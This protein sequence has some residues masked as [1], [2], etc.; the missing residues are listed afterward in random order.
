MINALTRT[1]EHVFGI[2][3]P[4]AEANGYQVFTGLAVDHPSNAV[5]LQA[6]GETV[7]FY[8]T[9]PQPSHHQSEILIR[10]CSD[11]RSIMELEEISNEI[12]AAL[13]GTA[14]VSDRGRVS[15]CI[16]VGQSY[17]PEQRNSGQLQVLLNRYELV[18]AEASDS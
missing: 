5:I 1:I 18:L 10:I 12:D 11:S 4:I 13:Q 9:G 14:G 16:R 6:Y 2:V 15:A 3:K 7:D 8:G 17:L